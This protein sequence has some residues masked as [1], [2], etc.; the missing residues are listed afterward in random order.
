MNGL[1]AFA[2]QNCFAHKSPNPSHDQNTEK[3]LPLILGSADVLVNVG[4]F[5]KLKKTGLHM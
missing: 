1:I 4:W 2:K 3:L 5:P